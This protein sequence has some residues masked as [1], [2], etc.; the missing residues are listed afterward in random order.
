MNTQERKN[1][2]LKHLELATYEC[3]QVGFSPAQI[4]E[5]FTRWLKAMPGG[6]KFAAT[7]DPHAL[8]EVELRAND[9][10]FD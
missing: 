9:G 10:N 6:K 8:V 2:A 1:A 5:H 4:A 7:Y 3:S